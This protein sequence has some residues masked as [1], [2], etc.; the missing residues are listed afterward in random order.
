M[1]Q[2]HYDITPTPTLT[3]VSG[4]MLAL[5]G[6]LRGKDAMPDVGCTIKACGTVLS[7]GSGFFE[8]GMKAEGQCPTGEAAAGALD[9]AASSGMKAVPWAL[10]LQIV[11]QI[12]QSL[13]PL[14][15]K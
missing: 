5:S 12:L 3:D 10:I 1:K 2:M 4:A 15:P 7:Y 8:P 13:I 11:M 6:Y 14:I 9:A